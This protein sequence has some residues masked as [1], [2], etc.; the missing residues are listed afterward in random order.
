MEAEGLRTPGPAGCAVFAVPL[1]EE[2]ERRLFALVTDLRR[3]GVSADIATG[4]R[5]LKGAMK[6]ADRSGATF[7][8]VVGNRDLADGVAQVKE[9]STGEQAELAL[10]R[11]AD[12]LVNRLSDAPT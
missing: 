5:G 2:A 7:A 6:A 11:L 1:G 12:E 10:D 8:V 3:A 9:M 4:G